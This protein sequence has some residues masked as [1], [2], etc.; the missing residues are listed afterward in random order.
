MARLIFL[1]PFQKDYARLS[2]D[3]Q[4]ACDKTLELL[5]KRPDYPSLRIKKMNGV[6]IWEARMRGGYR[7]T[8]RWEGEIIRVRRV[9]THNILRDP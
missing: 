1:E 7:I 4:K 5:S 8:F 9:G 3:L 6:D 2:L